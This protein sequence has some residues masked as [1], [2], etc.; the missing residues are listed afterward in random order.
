[1]FTE[2]LPCVIIWYLA[3]ISSY[4]LHFSWKSEP[5]IYIWE[6]ICQDIDRKSQKSIKNKSMPSRIR[7]DHLE[8]PVQKR[9]YK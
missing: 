5:N 8:F 9:L 6:V 2:D 3:T 4:T 1:M 7:R